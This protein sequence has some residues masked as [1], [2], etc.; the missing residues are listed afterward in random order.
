M[1]IAQTFFGGDIRELSVDE[2]KQG[3]KDFPTTK[4]EEGTTLVDALI[5]AKIASSKREARE[6]INGNSIMVNGEKVKDPAFELKK[7]DAF[8]EE[9]TVIKKGKKNWFVLNF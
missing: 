9:L 7:A 8:N 4:I 1:K 5:T 3:V 2:L 6:L